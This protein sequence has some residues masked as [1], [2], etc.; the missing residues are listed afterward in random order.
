VRLDCVIQPPP[1]FRNVGC[2]HVFQLFAS[3]SPSGFNYCL[4]TYTSSGSFVLIGLGGVC[5]ESVEV[6]GIESWS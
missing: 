6:D 2:R 3:N 4:Y 1:S 5:N